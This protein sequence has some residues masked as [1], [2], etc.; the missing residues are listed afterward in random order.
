MQRTAHSLSILALLVASS[1]Q[2]AAEPTPK[3]ALEHS[4]TEIPKGTDAVGEATQ[5]ELSFEDA[6]HHYISVRAL[7]P[8]PADS[9]V[10]LSMAVWT[11]GSYLVR[12]YARHIEELQFVTA[13]GRLLPAQKSS[14]NRWQV[15]TGSSKGLIAEYKLYCR[16]LSVRTNFVDA[17]SAVLN[18]APT[19]LTMVEE[20]PRKH[21]VKLNLPEGW[22]SAVSGL[23]PL[24]AKI[25]NHFTAKS[26]D[27]LVDSPIVAGRDLVIGEF[28]ITDVPHRLVHLG[29]SSQWDLEE[30]LADVTILA[31]A[32]ARFWKILPY[33]R[34]DFL[35]VILG[36]GGGLEHLDSTL[37]L[38]GSF[39]TRTESGYKRWL[40]LVAHEFFHTWNVKR[41]RPASLGPFDYEN[42]N[43][44]QSL[45]IAEG[46]TS[47]YDD[48]LLRRSGLLD[49]EEYLERLGDQIKAL[50]QTPGRL[51]QSLSSASFDSWIKYYRHDENSINTAISYYTKGAVV[52]F[53]LDARIRSARGGTKSL[54]DL[55]RLLYERYSGERGYTP[56]EFVATANEV[57]GIDMSD[58]FARALDSTQELD[59]QPALAYFGLELSDAESVAKEKEEAQAKT[60]EEDADKE[61]PGGWL[62]ATM[63]KDRVRSVK[64]GT[65]AFDAGLNANDEILAINGYR[66]RTGLDDLLENFRPDQE[67]TI[68]IS[69]G[70]RLR[71][72]KAKLATEPEGLWVLSESDRQ[73]GLQA[74]RFRQWIE[75]YDDL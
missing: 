35:N 39:S 69:R 38:S 11:P 42:E 65:P 28:E 22:K 37:M 67:V 9:D 7:F 59:Y 53:L 31:K 26:Y 18:G 51:V 6:A 27:E 33:K 25:E 13:E 32:A 46:I 60:D 15:H 55:M 40:G 10:E 20:S 17:D 14:K 70:G 48:L 1:C 54:D 19:F 66:L 57:S 2:P 30:T 21:E 24:E 45:W 64:R 44:T 63:S 12:E 72:L 49:E 56:E 8:A 73:T 47:Y 50:Q 5:Y 58:F 74:I 3:H 75:E 68:T 36:G 29:D 41:L 23:D 4:P 52:A 34:Y 43:Y 71:E 61:D 16:E 62:G